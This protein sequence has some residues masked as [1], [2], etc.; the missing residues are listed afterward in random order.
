MRRSLFDQITAGTHL[1]HV[2]DIF[3]V[4]M[5][6]KDEHSC[7]RKSG[8]DF[9]ASVQAIEQGHRNIHDHYRWTKL[10]R[11]KHCLS[12]IL[13]FADDD[14]AGLEREQTAQ[15]FPEDHMIIREEDCDWIHKPVNSS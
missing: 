15:P 7:F 3:L 6:G 9:A 5:S 8:R 2:L 4:A 13:G 12:S 1:R 10:L 14:D 11:E